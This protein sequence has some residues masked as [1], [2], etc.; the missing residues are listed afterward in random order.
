MPSNFYLC[1]SHVTGG[2][3]GYFKTDKFWAK[4]TS[5]GHRQE[6]L[7]TFNDDADLYQKV[8]TGPRWLFP[9]AKTEGTDW[10]K[11]F[12]YDWGDKRKIQTGAVGDTKKCVSEMAGIS[13]L[14]L[15]EV[16]LKGTR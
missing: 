15:R 3:E 10:R 11:S 9:L 13:V 5:N 7:T 6:I 8:I 1:F 16:T 2:S 4:T 12:C 14:Y